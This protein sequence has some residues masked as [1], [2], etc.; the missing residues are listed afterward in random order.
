MT[1]IKESMMFIFNSYK[2]DL[3][4]KLEIKGERSCEFN[5]WPNRKYPNSSW[6]NRTI[7]SRCY[8]TI[9]V[10]KVIEN[11]RKHRQNTDANG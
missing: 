11:E 9:N 5:S 1:W 3:V 8:K 2:I 6:P 7:G 4:I 10:D